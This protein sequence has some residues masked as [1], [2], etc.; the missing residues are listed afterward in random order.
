MAARDKLL[1]KLAAESSDANW[2]LAE[3]MLLLAQKGFVLRKKTSGSSHKIFIHPDC[4]D[5]IVLAAHGKKIKSGYVRA[6]R[7]T[8]ARMDE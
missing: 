2:T 6:I 1:L 7:E 5:A 8:F 3:A 4:D